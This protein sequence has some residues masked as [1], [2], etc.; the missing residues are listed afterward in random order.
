MNR[1]GIPN[2]KPFTPLS[3]WRGERPAG[4]TAVHW[5]SRAMMRAEPAVALWCLHTTRAPH[6]R[7]RFREGAA[8]TNSTANRWQ[9]FIQ[10][11]GV[12]T[13]NDTSSSTR[14]LHPNGTDALYPVAST[15]SGVGSDPLDG[16]QI[17]SA[18]ARF[19][20]SSSSRDKCPPVL[21]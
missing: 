2:P 9:V 13:F 1:P 16:G 8:P 15:R 3:F 21:L 18:A 12:T 5:P 10:W 19:G 6:G 4:A 14:H 11:C 17:R 20:W 7:Y